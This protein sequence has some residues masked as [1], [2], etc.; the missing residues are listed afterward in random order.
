MVNAEVRIGRQPLGI[1]YRNQATILIMHILRAARPSGCCGR[2]ASLTLLAL[3]TCSYVAGICRRLEKEKSNAPVL[4]RRPPSSSKETAT[5]SGLHIVFRRGSAT[6]FNNG[7]PVLWDNSNLKKES[8]PWT[9]EENTGLVRLKRHPAIQTLLARL[10]HAGGG[11]G[12]RAEAG[13]DAF[14]ATARNASKSAA[15]ACAIA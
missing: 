15:A 14:S 11:P 10:P 3:C 2:S 4:G 6:I 12:S 9:A 8:I 7:S 5:P 13:P 1:S